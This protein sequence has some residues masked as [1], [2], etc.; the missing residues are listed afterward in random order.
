MAAGSVIDDGGFV[1]GEGFGRC[2]SE[3][4]GRECMKARWRSDVCFISQARLSSLKTCPHIAKGRHPFVLGHVL[5]CGTH[6]TS[7]VSR[8]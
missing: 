8:L 7:R 3:Q 5:I 4:S 1:L 2:D 6:V